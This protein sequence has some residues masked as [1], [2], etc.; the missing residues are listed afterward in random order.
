MDPILGNGKAVGRSSL[1]QWGLHFWKG[2]SHRNTSFPTTTEVSLLSV[3]MTTEHSLLHLR[4]FPQQA[5]MSAL[6]WLL[7]WLNSGL[8]RKFWV[9]GNCLQ[10]CFLLDALSACKTQKAVLSI[11]CFNRYH[12]KELN[13]HWMTSITSTF[14][15]KCL[16]PTSGRRSPVTQGRFAAP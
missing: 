6:L 10:C 1:S 12:C 2:V 4:P 7:A 8:W 5:E 14:P 3:L 16:N 15:S 11:C 13:D 9:H